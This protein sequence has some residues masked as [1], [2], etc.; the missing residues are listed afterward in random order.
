M[1]EITETNISTGVIYK[2]S[3]LPTFYNSLPSR[4][5]RKTELVDE[6]KEYNIKI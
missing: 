4:K 2:N 3:K 5:D 6:V 1:V